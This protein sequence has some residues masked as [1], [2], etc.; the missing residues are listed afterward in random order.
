MPEECGDPAP[1]VPRLR[2][3]GR[4]GARRR[5]AGRKDR[6]A[7]RLLDG[8][9]QQHDQSSP[10]GRSRNGGRTARSQFRDGIAKRPLLVAG[11]QHAL[12][13][14]DTDRIFKELFS[15]MRVVLQLVFEA[16]KIDHLNSLKS[17]TVAQ[18]LYRVSPS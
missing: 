12:L 17:R 2:T 14:E 5:R 18:M 16:S 8:R 13:V 10:D 3:A 4:R 7:C 11:E 1:A 9:H 6:A 15:K